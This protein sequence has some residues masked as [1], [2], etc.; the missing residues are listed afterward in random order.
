MGFLRAHSLLISPHHAHR[1]VLAPLRTV[2]RVPIDFGHM[3]RFFSLGCVQSNLALQ[4]T[5]PEHP[6][7]I[8][9]ELNALHQVIQPVILDGVKLRAFCL[10]FQHPLHGDRPFL[11][12]DFKSVVSF[13]QG[14]IH[15][16]PLDR[17]PAA[18]VHIKAAND[19]LLAAHFHNP[20]N[21]LPP[22][23]G[24][25]EV[26]IKIGVAAV[27][28]MRCLQLHNALNLLIGMAVNDGNV[29][30]LDVIHRN[31]GRVVL[32]T[33]VGDVVNADPFLKPHIPD[34]LLVLKEILEGGLVPRLPSPCRR[35]LHKGQ[36]VQ[37]VR[38]GDA[39]LI[40]FENHPNNGGFVRFDDDFTV[41]GLSIAIGLSPARLAVFKPLA[42]AP[43]Q[44]FGNGAAFLLRKGSHDRQDQFGYRSC[45]IQS[46]LF[47]IE[48]DTDALQM[49]HIGQALDRVAGKSGDAF[50]HDIV[51][52]ACFAIFHHPEELLAL[53][54]A[55]AA[56]ALISIDIHQHPAGM[57]GNLGTEGFHLLLQAVELNLLIRADTG[58]DR[59]TD[60]FQSAE[61]LKSELLYPR[62]YLF[63]CNFHVFY[64]LLPVS[65]F[66]CHLFFTA[67][68]G[69]SGPS[70][71]P[72]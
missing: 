17:I 25:D 69:R 47:K 9:F 59:N 31:N 33:L 63:Y 14:S 18:A 66:Y 16:I 56:D 42:D 7:G 36:L 21:H 44:V 23:Q 54:H 39:V 49:T 46:F 29:V 71:V 20:R 30:V 6:H 38:H 50:R 5:F 19:A 28:P 70:A 45:C 2:Q 61:C 60:C 58:I 51:D 64:S 67:T 3:G 41:L 32:H 48:L 27:L 68:S 62:V 53:F 34:V 4:T 10:D 65:M 13:Q 37:D 40:H 57:L 35:S 8:L 26:R 11:S 22:T 55:G 12:L 1:L 43:F 52:L 24:A 72:H 15:K